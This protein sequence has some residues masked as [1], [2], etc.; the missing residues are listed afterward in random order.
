MKTKELMVLG[1]ESK[2]YVQHLYCECGGEYVRDVI[3]AFKKVFKED[4][5]WVIMHTCTNCGNI[6]YVEDIY[7]K[8]V[9]KEIGDPI[10][11]GEIKVFADE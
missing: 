10:S 5:K 6:I 4:G 1:K 9:E 3:K 7:P 11:F 2:T 8:V